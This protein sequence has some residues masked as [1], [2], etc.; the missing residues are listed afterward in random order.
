MQASLGHRCPGQ[1][2]TSAIKYNCINGRLSKEMIARRT[3]SERLSDTGPASVPAS[4]RCKVKYRQCHQFR[5]LSTWPVGATDAVYFLSFVPPRVEHIE[6]VNSR[7]GP[8]LPAP[9]AP[10]ARPSR[11]ATLARRHASHLHGP[12]CRK[13]LQQVQN[14]LMVLIGAVGQQGLADANAVRHVVS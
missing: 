13:A 5:A 4:G 1:D 3:L 8:G 12:H 11:L 9:D 7:W 2:P 6:V 14:P 10:N